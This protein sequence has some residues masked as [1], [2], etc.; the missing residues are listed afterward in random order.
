MGPFATASSIDL[1]RVGTDTAAVVESWFPFQL[2]NYG[3]V[4]QVDWGEPTMV[5]AE[6]ML[7]AAALE[8]PANQRFVLLS[9]RYVAFPTHACYVYVYGLSS[10]AICVLILFRSSCA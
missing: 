1:R 6:K 5:E 9:D 8:D 2:G 10:E 4:L 7:F 3:Y